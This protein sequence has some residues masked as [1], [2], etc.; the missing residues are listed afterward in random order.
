VTDGRPADHTPLGAGREFDAVRAL[1]ARWG[2][3]AAGVGDDCAVLDVP[4]GER[5]CVSTDTSVD[6]VHFRREWLT[7]TEIGYRATAAALSDLA[8]MA[9]RPL[10]LLLA[11]TVPAEWRSVL[12][13]LADGVAEAAAAAGAVIVG[14]DTTGGAV[15]SLTVTVL[16]S[17]A[18]P[19]RRGGARAGDRLYLT[20]RLGGPAA[21]L[22]ALERGD[23]PAPALR[24]R[25]EHPEPRIHEARWLAGQGARAMID[26]SDGLLADVAHLAAASGVRAVVDLERVPCVEG[27]AP[28]A[29]A[30]SGEEYELVCALPHVADVAEFRARFG[31]ALTEIGRVEGGAPELALYERGARV[32]LPRGYDHFSGR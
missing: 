32:D 14:G 7:P 27:V 20:G 18:A 29:A 15:L 11:A 23:K 16:G 8:A 28:R 25:F 6:G 31:V 21:A 19:V 13:E 30:A 24:A 17:A 3:A 5:L 4:P 26:L 9:A 12:P 22:G 1:L 2:D 10:A